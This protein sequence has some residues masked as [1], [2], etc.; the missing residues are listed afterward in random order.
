MRAQINRSS[1]SGKPTS[2][3]I[4]IGS[5]RARQNNLI[6]EN[7]VRRKLIPVTSQNGL[8]IIPVDKP[9]ETL[10]YKGFTTDV[11]EH[12]GIYCGEIKR[13]WPTVTWFTKDSQRVEQ[14]FRKAVDSL[15]GDE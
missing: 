12:N 14:A 11:Y 6:D 7:G 15:S 13:A 10:K 4:N 9:L 5:W 8:L 1:A 2:Y 3:R